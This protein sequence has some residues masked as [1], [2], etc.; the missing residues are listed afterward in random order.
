MRLP[1]RHAGRDDR[2]RHRHLG[3]RG[4]RLRVRHP[5]L[6]RRRHRHRGSY[7]HRRLHRHRDDRLARSRGHGH[8]GLAAVHRDDRSQR[9]AARRADAAACCR[10]SRR[11]EVR[12]RDVGRHRDVAVLPAAGGERDARRAAP[13]RRGCCRPA[14]RGGRAGDRAWGHRDG[15]VQRV[16]RQRW[17]PE[18][19]GLRVLAAAPVLPP[20]AVVPRAGRGVRAW[21]PMAWAARLP[22]CRPNRWPRRAWLPRRA[23]WAH[24]FRRP[25]RGPASNRRRTHAVAER[26][27]PPR[28]KTLI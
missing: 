16:R 6:L 7:R 9:R 22:R 23:H 4:N 24:H 8:R 2:R 27:E 12:H 21:G 28:W 14:V 10:A 18:P 20:A 19:R 11:G 17:P 13:R 15:R 26:R 5:A 1:L 25:C 3:V